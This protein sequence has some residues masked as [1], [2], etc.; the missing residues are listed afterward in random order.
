M[1]VCIAIGHGKTNDGTFDPGVIY[2]NLC[3]HRLAAEI[4]RYAADYYNKTYVE[5]CDLIN[6][7]AEFFLTDRIRYI[8]ENN[9]DFVAEL[10]LNSG[11]GT[12]P[13]VYHSVLSDGVTATAISNTV[14]EAF[15]FDDSHARTK[16]TT[17][18]SDYF[19]IIRGTRMPTV[20][21][22]CLFIDNESDMHLVRTPAGKKRMGEAIARAIGDSRGIRKRSL[23]ERFEEKS[24]SLIN[25]IANNIF[26][27]INKKI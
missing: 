23:A 26:N 1:S 6:C 21:V 17:S 4:G 10:H 19:A 11:G 24:A 18:G 15:G 7:D 9:Y 2:D 8:N 22:E 13:V 14:A 25:G 16:K 5:K 3:E 20:L 27:F 12:G